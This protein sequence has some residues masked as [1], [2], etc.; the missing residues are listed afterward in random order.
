[1]DPAQRAAGY[2][3]LWWRG[4]KLVFKSRVQADGFALTV[5]FLGVCV[6]VPNLSGR[7]VAH[8]RFQARGSTSLDWYDHE[9]LVAGNRD[10]MKQFSTDRT[11]SSADKRMLPYSHHRQCTVAASLWKNTQVDIWF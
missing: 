9:P 3:A 10:P 2:F 5:F 11:T 6:G 8:L 4:R 1:M 7:Q